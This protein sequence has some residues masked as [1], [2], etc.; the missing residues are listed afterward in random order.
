M[1][2]DIYTKEKA[3]FNFENFKKAI[4]SF[5]LQNQIKSTSPSADFKILLLKF[6]S[7]I[8]EELLNKDENN[9]EKNIESTFEILKKLE[10]SEIYENLFSNEKSVFSCLIDFSKQY[11]EVLKNNNTYYQDWII[12]YEN[13]ILSIDINEIFNIT[14]KHLALCLKNKKLSFDDNMMKEINYFKNEYGFKD[15]FFRKTL[16]TRDKVILINNIEKLK[17]A[18]EDIS[19]DLN[20]E[21]KLL[22][23]N[24]LISISF[25]PT[26]L[27]YSST[28]AYMRK[29]NE[30]Y[31]ISLGK[32]KN[33]NELKECY[34]HEMAHCFDYNSNHTIKGIKI[35]HSE[36]AII[37]IKDGKIESP[38]QKIMNR[39][40]LLN[41][42]YQQYTEK[43]DHMKKE[44]LEVIKEEFDVKNYSLNLS[45]KF[46]KDIEAIID[47]YYRVNIYKLIKISIS[48][49]LADNNFLKK[50]VEISRKSFSPE[51]LEVNY[52]RL[53]KKIIAVR[54]S[55]N[56]VTSMNVSFFIHDNRKFLL[57]E[58]QRNKRHYYTKPVEMFARAFELIYT[59][60]D[61]YS[62]YYAILKEDE[63]EN[64]KK[65]LKEALEYILPNNNHEIKIKKEM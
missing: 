37:D 58:D 30:S 48:L 60:E 5:L 9:L 56:Y 13:S 26:L 7:I 23:L 64:Y 29:S 34:I 65:L 59:K 63:K 12:K 52:N 47:N 50:A 39:E 33:I 20:V 54:D 51:E 40:I 4:S 46:K 6:S 3:S 25:E 24:G 36:Q 10:K 17:Q 53:D 42:D 28:A 16:T 1:D 49:L 35:K 15:I 18:L 32:Y 31:I 19:K 21:K 2:L 27:D 38:I 41:E 45:G 14:K 57:E 62:K 55:Y 43:Y 11:I 61:S 44:I 8:E 22:S